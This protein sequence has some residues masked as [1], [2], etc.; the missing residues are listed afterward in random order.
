MPDY[1]IISAIVFSLTVSFMMG[2]VIGGIIVSRI[3]GE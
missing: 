2:I 3:Y 1:F